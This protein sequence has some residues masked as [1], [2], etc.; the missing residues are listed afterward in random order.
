[1]KVLNGIFVA[2]TIA[3][4]VFIFSFSAQTGEESAGLSGKIAHKVINILFDEYE[5][6]EEEKQQEIYH[7]IHLIVRKTA[8]FCEYGLLATLILSSVVT[9]ILAYKNGCFTAIWQKKWCIFAVVTQIMVSVYALTDEFHQN[10]VEGRGPSLKDVF[11][12]SAGGFTAII[13]YMLIVWCVAKYLNK[14]RFEQI[15]KEIC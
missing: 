9:G 11:I 8:H 10:F 13:C 15:E 14:K 5:S 2:L 1:M 7:T 4:T 12:D 3:L 6:Y